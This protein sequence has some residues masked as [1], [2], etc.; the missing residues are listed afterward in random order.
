[1]VEALA[2]LSAALACDRPLLE[3]TL[4][5][6]G[7]V[8]VRAVGMGR[9]VD[10][11]FHG[12][13][14]HGVG[15]VASSGA[16]G[17][18]ATAR[19]R[20]QAAGPGAKLILLPLVNLGAG[21]APLKEMRPGLLRALAARG[22]VPLDEASVEAFLARHRVRYTGGVDRET[23]VA[24]AQEL[25][26]DGLLVT[27]IDLY[28]ESAPL[29]LMLTMR[30]V[31][32]NDA[33]ELLWIDGAGHVADESPGL[34]ELGVIRDMDSMRDRTFG[35]IAGSLASFLRGSGPRASPCRGGGRFE[36]RVALRSPRLDPSRNYS[37]AVMPFANESRR[38]GAGDLLAM[39]FVRN[40]SAVP[41]FTVIEPGRVREELLRYRIILEGGVSLDLARVVTEVLHADLVLTGVVRDFSEPT[42]GGAP[43]V[44]FSALLLDHS[45]NEVVWDS[46]SWNAGDDGVFFFDL[47]MVGTADELAC[48]MVRTTVE[49]MLRQRATQLPA[50]VR[51]ATPR[52]QAPPQ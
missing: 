3:A 40:L 27:S 13:S 23:A 47:G 43:R 34:F 2:A 9:R 37:V 18:E 25:G 38:R 33:V 31:A 30:L 32:A 4:P 39:D 12:F 29:K 19:A 50:P 5:D 52:A 20:V 45:K 46:T 15:V 42:G 28:Q 16:P 48:R 21:P 49:A 11:A 7:L 6:N 35:E 14:N 36:P 17:S 8:R 51:P 41:G 44:H 22:I 26:A 1:M 10:E 24:A